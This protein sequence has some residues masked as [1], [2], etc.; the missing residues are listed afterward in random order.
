MNKDTLYRITIT[1]VLSAITFCQAFSKVVE[2]AD[3][4]EWW[5]DGV[6]SQDE[7]EDILGL[8][9]EGN[10]QEACALAEVYAQEACI[11]EAISA[12][13]PQSPKRQRQKGA[14]II[15]HGF[16]LAKWRIDSTGHIASRREELQTTFYYYT[17][18]LG[19][20]EQLSYKADGYEAYFGDIAT[21][22]LHSQIPTDTLWGT[23]SFIPLWKFK[24]GG[25]LDS[26][27]TT[28]AHIG[29]SQKK[30]DISAKWWHRQETNSLAMQ[31]NLNGLK[32]A[33]WHQIKQNFPLVRLQ[34]NSQETLQKTPPDY[35]T[36]ISWSTNAYIHGKEIPEYA[37]ISPT[38]QKNK[39]WASQTV[40]LTKPQINTKI[41][42]NASILSPVDSD[43]IGAKFKISAETGPD[44]IHVSS[45]GSCPDASS[46]CKQTTWKFAISSR[47]GPKDSFVQL[48][49]SAKVKHNREDNLMQG[50]EPPRLEAGVT[51]METQ[52][53]KIRAAAIFPKGNPKEAFTLRTETKIVT[54]TLEGDFVVDFKQKDE[55]KLHPDKAFISMKLKF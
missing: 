54:K 46:N 8:L 15:P 5:D 51:Y 14:S 7:A 55:S 35:S 38:I 47:Q 43:S 33:A 4:F 16:A 2:E 20:L 19:S 52:Q 11:E 31:I 10:T 24:I 30:I 26:S 27:K 6:I 23:A 18:R 13:P 41:S 49:A 29:F 34:I 1:L 37:N 36:R 9:E 12:N 3:V 40:S 28:Q 48:D 39:V 53:S 25:M 21:R 42:G 17:L 22:E 44:Y 45:Y 32:V 50:F